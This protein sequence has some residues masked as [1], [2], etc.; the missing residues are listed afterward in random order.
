MHLDL[1]T[2]QRPVLHRVYTADV[3]AKP[4]L[5]WTC[6]Y[7][8]SL[9]VSTVHAISMYKVYCTCY[10]HVQCV[11][12]LLCYVHE[13]CVLYLLCSCTMCTVPVMSMKMCTVPVMSMY[14]VYCTCYVHEQC[15]LYLLCPCTMCTVPVIREEVF[16]EGPL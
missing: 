16:M 3:C 12:Y 4:R 15:V 5:S 14:N 8:R 7:K 11:L 6:L 13:Q 10:V 1:T 2:L 9:V